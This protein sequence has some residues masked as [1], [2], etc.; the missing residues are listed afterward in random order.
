MEFD[1][2]IVKLIEIDDRIMLQIMFSAEK[3]I[4][5]VNKYLMS[6]LI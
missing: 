6:N 3:I 1:L 4:D 2:T 5:T